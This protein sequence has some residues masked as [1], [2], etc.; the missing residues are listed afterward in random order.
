MKKMDPHVYLFSLG[1]FATDWAQGGI[2]ALLPYFIATCHLSYQEAA[3]IIFANILLASVTQPITG[4][5]SDRMSFP[6]IAPF[7]VLL[8]GLCIS[9]MA[10]TDSYWVIFILSMLCGLG[11]SL[12]HPEAA[13]MINGIAGDFKGKAMGAFS[14]GGNAGFALGPIVCGLSAYTYGIKGLLVFGVV[15]VLTAIFLHKQM[16]AI[17]ALIV[18]AKKE[19]AAKHTQAPA[20]NDWKAFG[21]LTFVIFAR[22]I[23]FTLCNTFIPLYWINVLHQT[24]AS[25]SMAL[26]VLFSMGVVITFIGGILADRFGFIRILRVSFFVMVPAT[27]FLVNSA[28]VWL[29]YALLVPTALSLFAPYSAIVILGQ[30]YLGKN[31]GFASGVTLGLSGTVGGLVSPLV[32]WGADKWGIQP[33]LQVLWVVALIGC[34]FAFFVPAPK[35]WKE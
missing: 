4:Y 15:N 26:S 18:S 1:H 27:F 16:P 3:G 24:A 34:I 28:N 29:S 8:S 7:G 22:S 17:Q 2:P 30:T 19:E 33:A 25:G 6:W 32:G 13:R 12:Y 20:E 9:A 23:G 31:I 11:S 14:V 10:F 21:K 35:A 5:Y